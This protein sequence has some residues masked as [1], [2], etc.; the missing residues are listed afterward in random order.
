MPPRGSKYDTAYL[1]VAFDKNG[2]I[3]SVQVYF[4]VPTQA[5]RAAKTRASLVGAAG[6]HAY[7]IIQTSGDNLEFKR[8]P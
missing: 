7:R 2:A 3:E 4:S 6:Y 8:L 1:F 5:S